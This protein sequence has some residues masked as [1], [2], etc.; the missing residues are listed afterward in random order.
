MY[1]NVNN[2]YASNREKYTIF[3]VV[4]YAQSRERERE[5]EKI[6]VIHILLNMFKL[7]YWYT[8]NT[9]NGIILSTIR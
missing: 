7:Q 4:V 1:I 2:T 5:R 8:I 9:V 3:E 6:L